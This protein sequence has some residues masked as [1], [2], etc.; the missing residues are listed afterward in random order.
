LF[1]AFWI[2]GVALGRGERAGAHRFYR[3]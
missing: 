1:A 3:W 2:I